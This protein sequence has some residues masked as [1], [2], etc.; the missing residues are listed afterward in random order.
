MR[1]LLAI[2]ALSLCSLA[3]FAQTEGKA[4]K[5]GYTNV[6]YIFSQMP[7]SKEIESELKS[8]EAMLQKTIEEKQKELEDKYRAYEKGKNTMLES[9]RVDKE[10]ELQQLN[11]SI[12]TLR[13]NAQQELKSKYEELIAPES[14]KIQK[15]IKDV[16][17]ESGYDWVFN[18][19]PSTTL[20]SSDKNDVTDLVLKKLGVT[21]RTD[22]GAATPATKPAAPR[23]A[24]TPAPKKK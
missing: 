21:K 15:A 14:D 1:K 11:S 13:Q 24:A 7:R 5:L 18:G 22:A 9:I 8:R 6:E 10:N 4:L 20:Y 3:A 19:L 12:Q 23:P 17:E 2:L 16:A